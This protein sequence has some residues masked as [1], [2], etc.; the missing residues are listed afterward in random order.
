M[1]LLRPKS[2]SLGLCHIGQ[3]VK[4]TGYLLLRFAGIHLVEPLVPISNKEMESDGLSFVLENLRTTHKL[5]A[6]KK[7]SFFGEAGH[8][9]L[10]KLKRDYLFV[11]VALSLSDQEELKIVPLHA[12]RGWSFVGRKEET[13][14]FPLPITNQMFTAHLTEAFEIAS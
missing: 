12:G 6:S 9:A 8:K 2:K 13:Q 7:S 14:D 3:H 11:S 10:L 5:D 4:K 1:S